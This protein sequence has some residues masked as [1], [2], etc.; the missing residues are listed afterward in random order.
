MRRF[1]MNKMKEN[2]KYIIKYLLIAGLIILAIVNHQ[3][4]ISGL[5]LLIKIAMPVIVGFIMAY[6]LNIP[7]VALEKIYFPKSVNKF[8]V[9][10]R[11]PMSILASL[12]IITV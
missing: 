3:R 11:R 4:I 1:Q 7:M 5:G 12:V 2:E 8:V 9:K 10:S 6:I